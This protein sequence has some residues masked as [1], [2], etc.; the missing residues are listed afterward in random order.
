MNTKK[1]RRRVVGILAILLL[2]TALVVGPYVIKSRIRSNE[3]SAITSL[4]K[5]IALGNASIMESHTL[6][7]VCGQLSNAQND[8][9]EQAQV[10]AV[11][12]EALKHDYRLEFRNCSQ[13]A[14]RV[15][16]NPMHPG[17]IAPHTFCSDQTGVI[18]FAPSPSTCDDNSSVWHGARP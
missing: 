8:K 6:E 11:F 12:E 15:V 13:V 5:V 14:Y 3:A 4:Q 1:A 9:L 17:P 18:R 7:F 16:A 2:L 10:R